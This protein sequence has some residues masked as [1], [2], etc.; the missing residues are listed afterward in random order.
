M[1]RFFAKG[2]RTLHDVKREE[3]GFTLI[4]LLVVCIIIGILAAIA[5][6]MFLA[7]RNNAWRAAQESD[8]RNLAAVATACSADR[9][10]SYDLCEIALLQAPPYNFNNSLDVLCTTPTTDPG[11][12]V[13]NCRNGNLAAGE[14]ATFDTDVGRVVRNGY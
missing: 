6:P 9:N 7:Q 11:R 3:R 1:L 10:G 13:G 8:A 12:W 4:E 14:S 5:I 2:L